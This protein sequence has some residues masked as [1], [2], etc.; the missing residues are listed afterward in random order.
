M[1]RGTTPKTLVRIHPPAPHFAAIDPQAKEPPLAT[2]VPLRRVVGVD[3]VFEADD[4]E[5]LATNR[6]HPLRRFSPVSRSRID[7]S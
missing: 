2:L 1:R 3:T 7:S 5:T 6:N 4:A